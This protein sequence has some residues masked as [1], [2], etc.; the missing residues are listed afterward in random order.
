MLLA[1]GIFAPTLGLAFVTG[2]LVGV[3]FSF[4]GL[5]H[6]KFETTAE[7]HFYTP[8]TYIGV[9]LSALLIGRIAYRFFV[10]NDQSGATWQ[11]GHP[12]TSQML[13]T[14]GIIGLTIGY[15]LSYFIGLFW[16]THDKR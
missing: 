3:G 2:A 5:R 14:F 15:Y 4:L 6:T 10:L 7:G 13:V 16:H 9:A 12:I 1:A 8:N 11:P